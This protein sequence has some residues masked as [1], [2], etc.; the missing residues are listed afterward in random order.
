MQLFESILHAKHQ[1]SWLRWR[2]HVDSGRTTGKKLDAVQTCARNPYRLPPERLR[3]RSDSQAHGAS[4]QWFPSAHV[5]VEPSGDDPADHQQRRDAPDQ[6][7]VVCCARPG[8]VNRA[9]SSASS[10]PPRPRWTPA[11]WQRSSPAARR[12]LR[13]TAAPARDSHTEALCGTTAQPLISMLPWTRSC[14]TT[15][16]CTVLEKV[17][18]RYTGCAGPCQ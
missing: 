13:M 6:C 2:P 4:G 18:T 1:E 17:T 16:T 12:R 11:C 9:F 3:N 15:P 8:P 14:L 10:H 5:Q 7:P